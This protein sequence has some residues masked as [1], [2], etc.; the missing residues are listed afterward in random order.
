M[1]FLILLGCVVLLFIS[2]NWAA[3]TSLVHPHEIKHVE[4]D[5]YE[6][7]FYWRGRKC[8]GFFSYAEGTPTE[9]IIL[10]ISGFECESGLWHLVVYDD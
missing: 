9:E 8:Y 7:I 10:K 2:Q 5:K 6:C 3:F 4:F 1:S